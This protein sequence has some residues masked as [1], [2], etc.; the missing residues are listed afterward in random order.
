MTT[1]DEPRSRPRNA[2]SATRESGQP[3]R[4]RPY[5]DLPDGGPRNGPVL[6]PR[7]TPRP[8]V[9][10][11]PG[12]VPPSARHSRREPRRPVEPPATFVRA[13]IGDEIRIPI[14]WCQFGSCIATYTHPRALG[15]RDLR[16]RALGAGWRYDAL[17]RLAC[18]D[19]AQHDTAFWA[20]RS[21][22]LVTRRPGPVR[23][24]RAG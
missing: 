12:P 2:A 7:F 17:G 22:A 23:R 20:R 13:V 11:Q 16:A 14:M 3:T 19:C 1:T 5:L 24:R 15:E 10:P 6:M 21:P 8:P 18:P 9:S 4:N